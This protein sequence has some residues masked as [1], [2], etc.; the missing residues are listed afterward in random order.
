MPNDFNQSVID[1][2]RSAKGRLTGYFANARLLLL[3]TTGAR[4]GTRHTTPVG[5]LP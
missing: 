1:E 2:F 5:Y 4:T 3:T